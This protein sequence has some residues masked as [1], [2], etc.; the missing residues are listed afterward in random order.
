MGGFY[1]EM[2]CQSGD[3]EDSVSG[4]ISVSVVKINEV[5][6]SGSPHLVNDVGVGDFLQQQL[7]YKVNNYP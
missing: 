2:H 7:H 6:E 5:T 1:N 4:E 3:I